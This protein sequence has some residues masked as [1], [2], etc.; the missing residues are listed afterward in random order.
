MVL[1]AAADDG[2]GDGDDDDEAL[3]NLDSCEKAEHIQTL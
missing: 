3:A 1:D 2:D